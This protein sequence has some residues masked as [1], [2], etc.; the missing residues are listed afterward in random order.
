MLTG[1]NTYIL[2][3][4]TPSSIENGTRFD[5]IYE[6]RLNSLSGPQ[7]ND[8]NLNIASLSKNYNNGTREFSL[9]TSL[10]VNKGI[11]ILYQVAY[12]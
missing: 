1:V 3:S 6:V 4:F 2:P 11:Y 10:A 5:I 7:W 12:F 8:P 9:N